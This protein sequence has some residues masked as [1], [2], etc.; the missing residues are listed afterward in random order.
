MGREKVMEF[1]A[2]DV[3]A[4][5]VLSVAGRLDSQSVHQFS[6][7]LEELGTA[8]RAP[9]LL[10]LSQLTYISSAGC[11]ALFIAA[12]RATERGDRL[13]LCGMTAAVERVVELAGLG[14]QIGIYASRDEA[15]TELSVG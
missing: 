13:A 5:T 10:E 15:V 11:R 2:E 4:L 7:R 9:V 6:G 12:R 3:A 1:I 14:T 8:G